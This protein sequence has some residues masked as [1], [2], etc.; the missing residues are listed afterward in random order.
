MVTAP[1]AGTFFVAESLPEVNMPIVEDM[2]EMTDKP[3]ANE[4]MDALGTLGAEVEESLH[5][6]LQ[7]TVANIKFIVGII[8]ILIIAVGSIAAY[9]AV[10]FSRLDEQRAVMAGILTVADP[11]QRAKALEDF[12]ANA[13]ASLR[14]AV[15]L[16]LVAAL[17]ASGQHERSA[18]IWT[19][20][21]AQRLGAVAGFGNAAEL[22]RSGKN[23]QALAVL[24]GMR[25]DIP[26][27]YL[28]LLLERIAYEAE[29]VGNL[30]TAIG[31]WESMLSENK[32]ASDA[33]ISA[34]IKELRVRKDG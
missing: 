4:P 27:A 13:P 15:D 14:A 32:G 17:S 11:T 30:E 24:E 5:P 21:S 18:E 6:F 9:D 23:A 10:Q 25:A 31:A 12:A 2:P 33:F 19:G 1:L 7:W 34:K 26:K 20:L 22:S 8:A 3:A 28:L 29:A 16:D